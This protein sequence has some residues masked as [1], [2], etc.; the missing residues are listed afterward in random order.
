MSALELSSLIL[1]IEFALLS[2]AILFF[3]LRRQRRQAQLDQ[4]CAGAAIRK[5][6]TGETSRRDTLATLFSETYRL[7]GDELAARVDEYVAREKAFYTAMITLYLERDG[8]RLKEIPA[9]LAKVLAPWAS[10]TPNGMVDT[11]ALADLASEKSELA[12]ERAST[13]RTLDELMNEYAAAFSHHQS[14]PEPKPEPTPVA[15]PVPE[16]APAASPEAAEEI[17]FEEYDP[18]AD[19]ISDLDQDDFAFLSGADKP[20]PETAAKS[21]P[22]TQAPE[23]PPNRA[24]EETTA[25]EAMDE[26]ALAREEL[27]GLADLFDT[28]PP[29][30]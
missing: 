22:A 14:K 5:L 6:K 11:A 3:L 9:E 28:G 15:D 20:R 10:L 23:N 18:D 19:Q 24:A 7:E 26:D 2:W 8:E 12:A 30:R 16:T 4:T 13:K 17:V 29:T 25:A 27:E 1:A 21:A